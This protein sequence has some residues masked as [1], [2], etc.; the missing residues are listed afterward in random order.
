[1]DHPTPWQSIPSKVYY[2]IGN[3]YDFYETICLIDAND[4]VI[5]ELIGDTKEK[6]A[7][8]LR[9]RVATTKSLP[10]CPDHRDKVKEKHCLMCRVEYL[11]NSLRRVRERLRPDME[12]VDIINLLQYIISRQETLDELGS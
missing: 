5:C 12:P 1:M 6:A 8:F 3:Q 11:E 2:Q 9:A 7:H 4:Q 10:L